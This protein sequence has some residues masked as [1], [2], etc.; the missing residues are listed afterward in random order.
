MTPQL[1][2]A[3][4]QLTSTRDVEANLDLSHE[5]T[6]AAVEAGARVVA[7]P[8]NFGFLGSE[9]AKLRHAQPIEDAPFLVGLRDIARESKVHVL[10]GSII[11]MPGC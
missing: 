3:A 7:L 2:V 10:A 11:R 8:E 6:R 5:L 4:V 1:E 9:T